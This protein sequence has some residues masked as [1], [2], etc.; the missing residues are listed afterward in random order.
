MAEHCAKGGRTRTTLQEQSQMQ[1]VRKTSVMNPLSSI[2]IF[3]R[4]M[5][6]EDSL[7]KFLFHCALF[8]SV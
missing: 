6:Q 2:I 7:L 3:A 8:L 4:G 1:T 5:G